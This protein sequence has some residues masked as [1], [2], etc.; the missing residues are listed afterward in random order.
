MWNKTEIKHCRRF[1]HD[2]TFIL[3]QFYF[4]FI[5]YCASRFSIWVSCEISLLWLPLATSKSW[6]FSDKKPNSTVESDSIIRMLF[7]DSYWHWHRSVHHY[8]KFI[9]L[10]IYVLTF[11]FLNC[12]SNY[13]TITCILWSI[14]KWIWMNEWIST[15][16]VFS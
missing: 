9:H 1:S 16:D 3:C 12:F 4:R 15:V 13:S 10:R 2:I 11:T 8:C 5:S 6:S 14:N 7:R